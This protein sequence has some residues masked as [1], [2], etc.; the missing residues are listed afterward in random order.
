ML[1]FT[2]VLVVNAGYFNLAVA[3][4]L[5]SALWANRIS[6]LGSVF[7]PMSML[8]IILNATN[9]RT[10]PLL[11]AFLTSI[12]ILI[13]AVTASPGYSDIYYK[14]VSFNIVNG[15]GVLEK[16]YGAWHK[17]YLIYLLCY[18]AATIGVVVRTFLQKKV[19]SVSH[20]IVLTLAVTV[21]LGVWFIEQL[22]HL[23]F[24]ILSVSYIITELFLLCL[25]WIVT[26]NKKL[27]AMVEAQEEAV[28]EPNNSN[29][30]DIPEESLTQ[31][32]ETLGTLTKTE[33]HIFDL[34]MQNRSTKEILAELNIKE[35]TLKFHNKNLY[36][37]LGVSSRKQLQW[38]YRA[39]ADK[40]P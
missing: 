39:Y 24:E 31:L 1:L 25:N 22:I 4:N 10:H 6:Y 36:G 8:M 17:I 23:D 5:T 13:F 20:A 34:Y 15:V 40:T 28:K 38:Q 7:L 19:S 12:G 21:N 33:R 27:Q 16:V 9:T 18:Y 2:S 26:E 35:N 30:P 11:P 3:T 14:E 37:K 29:I 32:E